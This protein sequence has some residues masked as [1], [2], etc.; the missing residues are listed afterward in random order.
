MST[1][2]L[3]EPHHEAKVIHYLL[4]GEPQTTKQQTMTPVEIMETAKPDPV[5]PKTHYLVQLKGDDKISYKDKP[6]EP[7]E[8]RN[9]ARFI[10]VSTGPTPVS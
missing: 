3:H 1:E 9:D 8:M 6:N 10:T 5:D 4:D 7:I 2:V